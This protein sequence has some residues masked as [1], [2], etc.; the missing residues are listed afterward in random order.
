MRE[1]F[2]RGDCHAVEALSRSTLAVIL[3]HQK[4]AI[5]FSF[6]LSDLA[7]ELRHGPRATTVRVGAPRRREATRLTP[8]TC[9][10]H[11]PILDVTGTPAPLE[12]HLATM[13]LLPR[14]KWQGRPKYHFLFIIT[15]RRRRRRNY[16]VGRARETTPVTASASADV[17]ESSGKR[18]RK[19]E[20]RRKKKYKGLRRARGTERPGEDERRAPDSRTNYLNS[21]LS[22]PS[23][24]RRK[25]SRERD[26]HLPPFFFCTSPAPYLSFTPSS[27]V[28]PHS[29][30]H[31]RSYVLAGAHRLSSLSSGFLSTS[32][33]AS[34]ERPC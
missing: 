13:V 15:I 20:R 4:P 1:G 22:A 24:R 31:A 11:V 27:L 7:F 14:R 9:S 26:S 32:P 34:F 33:A 12:R 18:K 17:E 5:T 8:A 3:E 6:F 21:Q 25:E 10:L 23:R 30:L 2:L 28:S 16:S 29:P 19:K